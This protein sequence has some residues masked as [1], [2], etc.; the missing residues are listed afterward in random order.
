LLNYTQFDYVYHK[1]ETEKGS[2]FLHYEEID[3]KTNFKMLYES[4]GGDIFLNWKQNS[5]FTNHTIQLETNTGNIELNLSFNEKIGTDFR[6]RSVK[7]IDDPPE[8]IKAFENFGTYTF[9]LRT[10]TGE[11]TIIRDPYINWPE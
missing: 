3:I 5:T 2:I 4:H 8:M 11:I 10:N 1:V 7:I 6:I 9:K